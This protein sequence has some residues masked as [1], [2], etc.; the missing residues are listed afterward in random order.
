MSRAESEMAQL[1][2]QFNFQ[3]T[4]DF[5]QAEQVI[6]DQI[7][8]NRARVRVAADMSG[9]GLEEIQRDIAV[10]KT[11][12]EDALREFEKEQ[13]LA[14]PE[15]TRSAP[16]TKE[17]G[18]AAAKTL[19][20]VPELPGCKKAPDA[21]DRSLARKQE[22][23]SWPAKRRQ[24]RPPGPHRPYSPA[25]AQRAVPPWF[26]AWARDFAELYFA[27]T[28][29]LFVMHGN[30]HDLIRLGEGERE[31]YGS[32][33]EFLGSQLFATWDVVLRHD[34]SQ[35]L[36]VFAG[37]NIERL[38]R[39]VGLVSERIGEPKSWTRD[40][41]AILYLLDQLIAGIL[42]EEDPAK[43]ISLGIVLDHAQY[44]VPATE[45]SQLAGALGS[46]LVRLLSWAQNPYI[47]RHNIAFCLLCDRLAEINDRLASSAHVATL[48]VPMP[49]ARAREAFATWYDQEDG[50][51]GN[52]TEFQPAQ[53]AELTSG[54]NLV[55]LERLLS[56]AAQWGA[57]ST[58]AHSSGSRKD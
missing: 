39:M 55:N 47:K 8:R 22:E 27:G 45:L 6:Q 30:V 21:A 4:G 2:T 1:A 40:P 37:P 9:E 50:T 54:L 57:S 23:R 16:V 12:G 3:V 28:T 17:L 53:L 41:D 56:H 38:R 42:M 24:P 35:G 43:Q 26:P 34:L 58:L 11:M 14:T 31:G 49:D 25:K 52:L 15:T 13:G 7:D 44:L 32:L 36:R 5:G 48:E 29:C 20:P 46:R 10:E 33:P 19:A 18:P 51:L